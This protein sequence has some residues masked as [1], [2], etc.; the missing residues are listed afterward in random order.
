MKK[1]DLIVKL[2]LSSDFME[3]VKKTGGKVA[4]YIDKKGFLKGSYAYFSSMWMTQ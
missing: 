2:D 3:T 4:L 1:G